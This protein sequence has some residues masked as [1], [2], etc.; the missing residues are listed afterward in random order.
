MR[1][2]ESIHL[3]PPKHNCLL[4]VGAKVSARKRSDRGSEWMLHHINKFLISKGHEVRVI[5]HQANMHKVA[6]PY[7]FEGVEVMGP[8]KNIDQYRWAD[9]IL[10]HLDYSQFTIAMA[11]LIKR[12]VVNLIHNDIPYS[13]IINAR[14]N[15]SVVYNSSWIKNK[16]AYEWP[17]MVLNPPCDVEY[18]DV[19]EKPINNEFITLISLNENKGGNVLYEVA[20]RMP[21]KKFLGV[22]GSYDP[23]IVKEMKNVTILPNTPD[24][25]EVYKKTRILLMP[26]RYE[27]WGRTATEAMASGIPV[28]CTPTPGLKE[29]CAYAGLYVDPR[30]ELLKDEAGHVLKDDSDVYDV[31]SIVEQIKKLD[32]PNFYN[33]MSAKCRQRAKELN[34][35]KQLN[36]LEQFIQTQGRHN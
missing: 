1:I 27:S 26:S 28:I 11:E 24:I 36:E 13:S 20:K 6:V 31:N 4:R 12:P 7:S 16:L 23:Q 19:C 25:R 15:N 18:Y 14:R 30:G 5:L 8:S 33:E 17:S 32:K 3:Y 35:E 34:P 21:H 9:I 29:N 22:M 10:T 2:L